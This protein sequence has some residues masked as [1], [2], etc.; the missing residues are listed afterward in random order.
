MAHRPAGRAPAAGATPSNVCKFFAQ[1]TCM[2]GDRCFNVHVKPTKKKD[3]APAIAT[4]PA[5]A[6]AAAKKAPSAPAAAA[7]AATTSAWAK[8]GSSDFKMTVLQKPKAAPTLQKIKAEWASA[9]EFVPASKQKS[10]HQGAWAD[11]FEAPPEDEEYAAMMASREPG[12]EYYPHTNLRV[13]C[14]YAEAS[15]SCSVE[16]CKYLHGEECPCC[17]RRCLHPDDL[18]YNAAHIE[19]CL[20]MVDQVMSSVAMVEKSAAVECCICMEKVLEKED[21][22]ER[23][24]GILQNCNHAFCLACVRS[25]R[26]KHDQGQSSARTCPICREKS[27]FVVPSS[28]WITDPEEKRA[29]IDEY[30]ANMSTIDCKHY[31]NGDG[32]CP[33]GDSCFYRHVDREGKQGAA[34]RFRGNSSGE[35]EHVR[36]VHLWDFLATRADDSL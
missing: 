11:L 21:R 14:P 22:S 13:L 5:A 9:A 23:R 28:V 36:P 34:T 24:F 1:G 7:A 19:S 32:A 4:A 27:F 26:S 16:G 6:A 18:E 2:Y 31:R 30:K 10:T 15:G 25:W 3:S 12:V 20:E 8:S 33:F 29:L 17:L 35:I